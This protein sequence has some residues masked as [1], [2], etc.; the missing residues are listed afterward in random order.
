[1]LRLGAAPASTVTLNMQVLVFPAVSRAVTLT[2]V[3]PTGNDEPDGGA[4]VMVT[5]LQLSNAVGVKTTTAGQLPVAVTVI[6]PGQVTVGRITSKVD[7]FV[8]FAVVQPAALLMR[9]VR[10]T[11]PLGPAVYKM[12]CVFVALLMIPLV[13]VQE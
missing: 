4:L 2:C 3:V 6:L 13:M 11:L 1:M 8:E 9:N 12:F 7:T 10:P 5:L